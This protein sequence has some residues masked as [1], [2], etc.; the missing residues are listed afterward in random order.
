MRLIRG[1]G[2]DASCASN[3]AS[4]AAAAPTATAGAVAVARE[5]GF[6]D[7]IHNDEDIA[8]VGGGSI[9]LLNTMTLLGLHLLGL[10]A[11]RGLRLF[12]GLSFPGFRCMKLFPKL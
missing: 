4:A 5:A 8:G 12:L 1:V 10:R 3:E 7:A 2:V 6:G 9:G 11:F